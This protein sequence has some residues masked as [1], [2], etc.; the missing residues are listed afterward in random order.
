[1]GVNE[2]PSLY[3]YHQGVV[4]GKHFQLHDQRERYS[5]ERMVQELDLVATPA[6]T[7]SRRLDDEGEEENDPAASGDQ[8]N[9][10][11]KKGHSQD[12]DGSGTSNDDTEPRETDEGRH[13]SAAGDGV[14]QSVDT[15][16]PASDEGNQDRETSDQSTDVEPP[17]IDKSDQDRKDHDDSVPSDATTAPDDDGKNDNSGK[18]DGNDDNSG[19]YDRNNDNSGDDDDRSRRQERDHA[20]KRGRG[21]RFQVHRRHDAGYIKARS[22]PKSFD[23]YKTDMRM[24]R[25]E[26][27]RKRRGIRGFVRRDNRKD[28]HGRW[29]TKHNAL[30]MTPGMKYATPG[31]KEHAAREV[32]LQKRMHKAHKKLGITGKVTGKIVLKKEALPWVKDVRRPSIVKKV[33]SVVPVVGRRFKMTPEEELIL[34]V[35]LSFVTGLESIMFPAG[36]AL[37]KKQQATLWEFLDL[38]HIGLP[39]EWGI[40][41]LIASLRSQ[42]VEISRAFLR[43][44]INNH[45]L[46]RRT[47]SPSCSNKD[48]GLTGYSCGMWK[49]LHV[50]TVGV[51]EQRGGLNLIESGMLGE[52][53]RV[54]SPIEAA[55]AIRDYIAEFYNCA[56]CKKNFVANYDD[57]NNNRRC[58]RLT[59][60]V[61]EAS[62]ADWKEL[63]VWLW[64]VHNEVSIRIGQEE[65]KRRSTRLIFKV[66]I[67][68][69]KV[70]KP[71]IA[72]IW[73]NMDQCFLCFNEDGT[74]DEAE[75]FKHLES[76][77]WPDSELDPRSERLV[78]YEGDGSRGT[79]LLL[80]MFM[81]MILWI[82]YK[83]I[84]VSSPAPLL[85]RA[86]RMV[87]TT[88]PTKKLRSN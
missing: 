45:P 70:D 65:E 60:D 53:S 23:R 33:V 17:V 44:V 36:G 84:R 55:D 28:T 34:D 68:Q 49:L 6:S 88:A 50:V 40:H 18:D 78:R 38:L 54:F 32:V 57:C 21:E 12:D 71:Q 1:M 25:E 46:P 20:P 15:Q 75:V 79:V 85:Y 5:V 56:V 41:R 8:A 22:Q 83:S 11:S 69:K 67:F 27:E 52:N 80:W 63:P 7:E 31:T 42:R 29:K 14:D 4:K 26:Y 81:L 19:K 76:V 74:W 77:Y 16:P 24:K 13:D 61:E 10:D 3:A 72:L 43:E 51:A 39:P 62:L 2:T 73:P 64:E 66:S 58:D 82:V 9:G 87:A 47:W 30:V 35:S 37:N 86:R 48:K 59:E